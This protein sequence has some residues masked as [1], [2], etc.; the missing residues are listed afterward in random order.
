MLNRKF[1]RQYPL[2][3]ILGIEE[4]LDGPVLSYLNELGYVSFGFEGGQHDSINAIEN[5]TIFI[6]LTMVFSGILDK[7]QIAFDAYIEQW[8]GMPIKKNPRYMNVQLASGKTI[9]STDLVQDL[10][11][12]V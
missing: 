11:D 9:K 1:T 2:A 3:S 7:S 10:K 12:V 6:L 4:H 5:H 8:H